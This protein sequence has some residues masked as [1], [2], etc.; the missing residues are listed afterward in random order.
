[1]KVLM[2]NGSPH[3]YGTTYTALKE[4]EKI[5][6]EE[7]VE[8]E[9]FWIGNK[10][11]AGCIGCG[12]C[13]KEGHCFQNDVVNDFIDKV[14]TA[15]GFVFASPVH[16]A[17]ASGAMTSFMDRA[18]YSGRKLMRYKPAAIVVTAR[19][20]GTSAAFEQLLKYPTINEMPV[21]SSSYWN[22]LFGANAEDALQDFEGL[23]TMRNLA[24]NMIYILKCFEAGKE[25]QVSLP[26]S[27]EN[28]K[29]NF[30]R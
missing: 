6:V 9:I 5:F 11:I 7:N 23:A 4:M 17:A 1:M 29:T 2:V 3:Q 19:R 13:R 27:E 18:F 10:A 12:Y 16:F 22:N 15:D 14:K 24:R 30:I 21:V 26:A 8:N 28:I 20:A 25:K